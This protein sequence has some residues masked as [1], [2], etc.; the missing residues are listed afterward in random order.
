MDFGSQRKLLLG[1]SSSL[2]G[3]AG[4]ASCAG[5]KCAGSW[6]ELTPLRCSWGGLHAGVGKE[7]RAA[8]AGPLL[9][10][11]GKLQ[12]PQKAKAFVLVFETLH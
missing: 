1:T 9:G 3:R 7:Q 6:V 10:S 12:S 5:A 8:A 2:G 4:W 11:C